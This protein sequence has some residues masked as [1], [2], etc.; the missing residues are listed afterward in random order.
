[1]PTPLADDFGDN[2][3]VTLI[4][5]LLLDERGVLLQGELAD[6][7]GTPIVRFSGEDGLL[8][9]V[10]SCLAEV[11]EPSDEKRRKS[12]TARRRPDSTEERRA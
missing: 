3:Y 8:E 10:R 4:A 7:E 6:V 9:A 1:L 2:R 5:R 11:R 12:T